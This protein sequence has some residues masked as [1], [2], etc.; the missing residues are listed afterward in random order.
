LN[1]RCTAL[2]IKLHY[3]PENRQTVADAFLPTRW[4][5]TPVFLKCWTA[6]SKPR[7]FTIHGGLL[8]R[9]D[10][11][12]HMAAIRDHGIATIDLL[13]VNLYRLSPVASWLQLEDAIENIDIGLAMVRSRRQ[14]TGKTW[15]AD[16]RVAV[17]ASAGRVEGRWQVDLTTVRLLVAFNRISQYDGA[18]SDLSSINFEENNGTPRAS[19]TGPGQQPA[20]SSCKTCATRTCTK[21]PVLLPRPAPCAR[22]AG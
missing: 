18:I 21:A 7:N 8:A 17:R 10:L 19:C 5:T 3:R 15:R 11:P 2:G 14:K 16:R 22:L 4:Q 9:R 6:A 1:L 20:S 12:E 13:V